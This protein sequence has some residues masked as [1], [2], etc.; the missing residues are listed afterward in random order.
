MA[1]RSSGDHQEDFPAAQPQGEYTLRVYFNWL[2][3]LLTGGAFL[4]MLLI[5]LAG[6]FSPVSPGSKVFFGVLS[7]V[8]FYP[9]ASVV[10]ERVRVTGERI[11]THTWLRGKSV[12]WKSVAR[13]E[14]APWSQGE[15]SVYVVNIRTTQGESVP[16]TGARGSRRFARKV[17]AD[18]QRLQ[19]TLPQR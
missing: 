1:F 3:I 5:G 10:T 8:T 2:L 18:L 16:L 13:I 15:G 9:L 7:A 11:T 4:V 14:V 12:P 6:L 19:G 17:A